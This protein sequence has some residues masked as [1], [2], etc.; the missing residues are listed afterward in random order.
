MD[1]HVLIL[2]FISEFRARTIRGGKKTCMFSYICVL[3]R[4][5]YVYVYRCVLI[6]TFYVYV[7]IL[8]ARVLRSPHTTCPWPCPFVVQL[9][10]KESVWLFIF[11]LL[12]CR[13]KIGRQRY[14]MTHRA[15]PWS[16]F[17][18]FRGC[19]RYRCWKYCNPGLLSTCESTCQHSSAYIYA[20]GS[21]SPCSLIVP[22]ARDCL[23]VLSALH[24]ARGGMWLTLD[25]EFLFTLH[26]E[27][28]L[29]SVSA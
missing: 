25:G 5:F 9:R 15:K 10:R 21:Q 17:C 14:R 2:L 1:V 23:C 13:W 4:I 22:L 18:D 28:Q 27:F 8:G 26:E 3:I 29:Q 16:V 24:Y 11:S 6:R 7:L 12:L 19:E 20:E